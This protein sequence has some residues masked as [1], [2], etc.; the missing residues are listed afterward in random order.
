MNSQSLLVLVLFFGMTETVFATENG[1]KPK[2]K[3]VKENWE[4]DFQIESESFDNETVRMPSQSD[5]QK[6]D[7][8]VQNW[9]YEEPVGGFET[10]DPG[11]E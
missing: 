1:A 10:I 2:I 8:E 9:K 6:K 5:Q 7:P 3:L 4:S 11:F